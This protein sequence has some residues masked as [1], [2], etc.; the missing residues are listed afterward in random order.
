VSLSRTQ[1]ILIGAFAVNG[2]VHLA[3]PEVY[4][5]IMPSW[6]PRHREVIVGS[7]VAELGLA[8]GL[9]MPWTRRPAGWAS[10]A[11]LLAV[12]PANIKMATD[13]AKGDNK[14][15]LVATLARLPFQFPMIKAAYDAT[16]ATK[17]TKA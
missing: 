4:E 8:A 3:K 13:A 6:V 2:V 5:P 9:A 10:I 16:K 7:G 1:K 15:M 17:A 12:Y 11:L 14:P